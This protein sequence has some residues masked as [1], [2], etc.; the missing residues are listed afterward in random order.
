MSILQEYEQIRKEMGSTRFDAISDY[1]NEIN[2]NSNTELFLSDVLYKQQEYAK[3]DAWFLDQIAPFK[4]FEQDN[5]I[6]LLLDE[7]DFK[8]D[9]FVNREV[10]QIYSNGYGWDQVI[11]SYINDNFPNML[12]NVY[13]DSELSMFCAYF[14]DKRDFDELSYNF[15]KLYKDDVALK[16]YI[17]NM[18]I[19]D[20]NI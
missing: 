9:V 17:D 5:S 12:D 18:K 13:F 10:D 19:I 14:N 8:S 6:A 16:D 7:E 3:F 1:L 20:I 4:L 15:I 2:K 11:K